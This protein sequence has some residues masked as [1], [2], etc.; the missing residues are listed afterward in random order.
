M[1]EICKMSRRLERLDKL[2]KVLSC[3]EEGKKVR[4]VV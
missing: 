3:E 4:M 1:D 2:E